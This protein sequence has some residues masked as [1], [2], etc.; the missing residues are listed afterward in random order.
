MLDPTGQRVTVMGLGRFGGGVGV[1]RWLCAQGCRVLVTDAKPADQLRE[2]IADIQELID[3]GQVTLRLGEHR[4][5]DFT[6]ADLVIA[7]PAV[8]RPWDNRYLCAASRA[9]VPITT[10]IRLAIERLP[11]RDRTVGITGSAGKSTTS[12]MV[13]GALKTVLG[14]H[15]VHLG[16]NIGGS[17]LESVAT[18]QPDDWAVLELSSAQLHWLTADAGYPGAPGFSPRIAVLTNLTPNHI[19]WHG[20]VMH[21]V[22][23][24]GQIAR[25]Q[26]ETLDTFITVFDGPSNLAL[27]HWPQPVCRMIHLHP[28]DAKTDPWPVAE[29]LRLRI[30]GA[31]NRLNARVAGAAAVAAALADDPSREPGDAARRC[32]EAI[33]AFPGLPHRLAFVGE[34]RGVRYFNDSKCTT[35]EAALLAVRAFADDPEVG[36]S[37]VHLIAG[38]YDK[39]SNLWPVAELA[40]DIAGLYCIGATGARLASVDAKV[41]SGGHVQMCG[42]LDAAAAAAAARARP[43]DVVLLSPACASWDQFTNYEQRGERFA[44]LVR[45]L[46]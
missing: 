23:S 30:P 40:F 6:G 2:P 12:A 7:N 8:P 46:T 10:E 20:D 33:S 42:T 36:L 31:H 11:S 43:G 34:A 45:G 38:G 13:A 29:H 14:A 19:D 32:A 39:G 21:Y 18:M 4:E 26:V 9:G 27:Y 44:A 5:S 16:G 37:R 28:L 22:R 35:P 25:D 1:T 3:A 41:G 15:R 24:K 17:L